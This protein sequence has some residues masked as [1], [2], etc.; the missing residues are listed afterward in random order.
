MSLASTVHELV[1][2]AERVDSGIVECNALLGDFISSLE[3]SLGTRK[4]SG[5]AGSRDAKG[6]MIPKYVWKSV[7]FHRF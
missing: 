1:L 6:L 5:D 4:S 2:E 7:P 3:G